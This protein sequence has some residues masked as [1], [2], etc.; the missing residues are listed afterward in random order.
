[1]KKILLCL[2]LGALFAAAPAGAKLKLP[3]LIGDHMVLQKGNPTVWGWADPGAIVT[4]ALGHNAKTAKADDQ[5]KW[6]VALNLPKAGGP[7]ELT[8]SSAGESVTV[9]D[10]LIGEVW[11][12]SGQS[13]M[14]FAMKTSSDADTEI[15][16]AKFPKI[17]LFTVERVSSL[18]PLEDVNGSW[19]ICS[20][21][22]VGD[23][24]AVLYH[25]G[26]DLQ[27]SLK[28]VPMGLILDAWSGSGA[29]AWTPHETL[30][31]DPVFTDLLNQWD[32]NDQQMKTW[33]T[34]DAFDLWI[35]DVVFIPKD[36]KASPVT[37]TAKPGPGSV[38][39]NWTTSAKPG[40]QAS[41]TVESGAYSG[42]PAVHFS[43]FMKGGG[44][45]GLTA[46][47]SFQN[48]PLDLRPY[49]S[50]EFFLKGTGQYKVTLGQ[51]SITDYDYYG[52]HDSFNAPASWTKMQI[53]VADLKQGGWG[54]PK[55]F[56]PEAVT[57]LNFPVQVAFWPDIVAAAYNG[58][59]APITP[60]SIRGVLW[61]QG[62]SNTGRASQYR[63]LLT[64]MIESWRQAWGQKFPFIIIQLPN[65]MAVQDNPS[66]SGWADLREAQLEVSKTVPQTGL[67]TTIDLGEEN[68][69]HP[70]DKTD[71]G[72]RAALVAL[73]TV[74]HRGGINGG[75]SFVSAK[76][77]GGKMTLK[78]ANAGRGLNA[79]GGAPLK[80]FALAG[81]DQKYYWADAKIQ[82]D[83][84]VV[85]S[86]QVPDPKMVRYAW[87][88]NPVCNLYNSVGLPA[89]PFQYSFP[90]KPGAKAPDDGIPPPP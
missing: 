72:H 78:F 14:E 7:Y 80:G 38:G 43:G 88:D 9:Q 13:N 34:G 33:T 51:A 65:F 31:K 74:Y 12:G 11:V 73:G 45:G 68:N 54:S 29:E 67:V 55:A 17:R 58:M 41:V 6:K 59:I 16:A 75:P 52:T 46:N 79:K 8:V 63:Q 84:V 53:N 28:K 22:T 57:T 32:H 90:L 66:E 87:A 42:K 3:A 37:V 40:C 85:S 64:H 1:M 4:V 21:D 50:I 26:K 23:F 69:I 62:E 15:P 10:V 24:S 83:T 19:K 82:G 61:Y 35:S 81:D 30:E 71:V 47:L 89:T 49:Q 36:P 27:K 18:T 70:K 60:C 56:T 5:G 25:F 86:A 20:P 44:W 2:V 76:V 39:G 48:Q 77:K